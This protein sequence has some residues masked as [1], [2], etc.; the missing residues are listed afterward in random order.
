MR[1]DNR[2]RCSDGL[3]REKFENVVTIATHADFIRFC[4]K[5]VVR[6]A[7]LVNFQS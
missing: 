7:T 3:G 6:L 5:F 2:R 1:G 4:G